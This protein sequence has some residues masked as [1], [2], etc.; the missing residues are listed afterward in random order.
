[1]VGLHAVVDQDA[2]IDPNAG[3]LHEFQVRPDAGGDD[4]DVRLHLLAVGHADPPAA[5][6]LGDA[7][8]GRA[9]VQGD[10]LPLQPVLDKLGTVPVQHARQHVAGDLDDVQLPAA[11][12]H[13]GED[14]EADEPSA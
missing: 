1:E 4:D 10:S 14:D 11:L 5:V 2:L 7:F 13:G 12:V 6:R 3:A 8:H 9:E